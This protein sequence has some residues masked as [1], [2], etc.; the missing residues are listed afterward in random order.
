MDNLIIF[1]QSIYF[2]LFRNV[3]IGNSIAQYY[4]GWSWLHIDFYK[5]Y[6]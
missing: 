6:F 3:L 1:T 2:F 4:Y 5:N